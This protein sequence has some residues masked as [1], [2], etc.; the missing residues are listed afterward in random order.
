MAI[1][2]TL[3]LLIHFV[4]SSILPIRTNNISHVNYYYV[5]ASIGNP[6]QQLSLLVDTSS[7]HTYIN[8]PHTNR[9]DGPT[10]KWKNKFLYK[11]Q[12]SSTFTWLTCNDTEHCNVCLS[13]EQRCTWQ[14]ACEQRYMMAKDI[15]HLHGNKSNSDYFFFGYNVEKRGR[16][17]ILSLDGYDDHMMMGGILALNRK[18]SSF[19]QQLYVEHPA[20]RSFAHYFNRNK[21]Y[22]AFGAD[23]DDLIQQ[24]AIDKADIEWMSY[25]GN[26]EWLY[27]VE[28]TRVSLND[29]VIFS[30]GLVTFDTAVTGIGM[31]RKWR[32][33]VLGRLNIADDPFC[34]DDLNVLPDINIE[35][36][37]D[38]T[39]KISP[40]QYVV[41]IDNQFCLDISFDEDEG[42]C[43]GSHVMENYLIIYDDERQ[44]IGI[45]DD[46]VRHK[47]NNDAFV[48]DSIQN[49]DYI[50]ALS[51]ALVAVLV[52]L[53]FVSAVCV[54][55]LHRVAITS[56]PQQAKHQTRKS[57]TVDGYASPQHIV[58]N[59]EQTKQHSLELNADDE[60]SSMSSSA[61]LLQSY[62]DGNVKSIVYDRVIP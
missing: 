39:Y 12:K 25:H 24:L 44:S 32:D 36:S 27:Q 22:M 23:V 31:S 7:S 8:P 17:H 45:Y 35:L 16:S 34:I 40:E 2:S 29:D 21:G 48:A 9:R 30:D 58:I 10:Q 42:V 18:Q 19:I 54:A 53:L 41:I 43:L 62:Y 37:A 49:K 13:Y 47:Y 38:M 60:E 52:C 46:N 15:I 33:L 4:S 57:I 14:F 5:V 51:L 28:L 59:S 1:F 55:L 6:P 61:S 26:D 50:Y 11:S 20:H 56:T 3:L